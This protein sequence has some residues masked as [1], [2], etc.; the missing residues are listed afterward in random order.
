MTKG[1]LIE[2]ENE[3]IPTIAA[4]PSLDRRR[5]ELFFYFGLVRE[6]V[7]RRSLMLTSLSAIASVS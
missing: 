4:R 1:Y 5:L 2:C 6:L 3:G 7:R